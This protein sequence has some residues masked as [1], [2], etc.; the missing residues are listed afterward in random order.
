MVVRKGIAR[1]LLRFEFRNGYKLADEAEAF[2]LFCKY[3]TTQ[4][5]ENTFIVH[6]KREYNGKPNYETRQL[7]LR[8]IAVDWQNDFNRFNYD[9]VECAA[10][11]S[12]FTKYG[13]R[14]GLLTEFT[15]NGII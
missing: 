12:F 3:Y 13:K 2:K 4:L 10:W 7:I 1:M 8:S 9:W 14:Y 6:E 5:D 11:A 15:E